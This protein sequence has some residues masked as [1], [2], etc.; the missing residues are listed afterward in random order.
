M[1][2]SLLTA[3]SSRGWE[4]ETSEVRRV[5]REKVILHIDCSLVFLLRLVFLFRL[6][7]DLKKDRWTHVN[8]S[9]PFVHTLNRAYMYNGFFKLK[10]QSPVPP[11]SPPFFD[12]EEDRCALSLPSRMYV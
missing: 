12:M 3:G 5:V 2:F 4:R 9:L 6:L 11:S 10:I 8:F 7:L 1:R